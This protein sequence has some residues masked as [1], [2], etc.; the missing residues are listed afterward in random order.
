MSELIHLLKPIAIERAAMVDLGRIL[1]AV[2]QIHFVN[3]S[4][5]EIKLQEG[6]EVRATKTLIMGDRTEIALEVFLRNKP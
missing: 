4:R 5:V 2:A 6:K 1:V 3:A